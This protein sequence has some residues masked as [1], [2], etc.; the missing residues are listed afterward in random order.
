[1]HTQVSRRQ[2]LIY[3]GAATVAGSLAWA[4]PARALRPRSGADPFPRTFEHRFGSTTLDAVPSRIITVGLTDHEVLL[5][6]GVAPLAVTEWFGDQPY[7]AWPWALDALGD[8]T[9]EVLGSQETNFEAIAAHEPDLVLACYGGLEDSDY[10]RLSGIAPT[11]AQSGDYADWTTPWPI[12]TETIARAVGEDAAGA[13]LIAGIEQRFA[14]IRD[15]NPAFAGATAI[16]VDGPYDGT[17]GFFSPG[18]P[19]GRLLA[20]LGFAFPPDLEGVVP[21]DSFYGEVS[22]E[23]LPRLDSDV[24][25]WVSYGPDTQATIEADPLYPTLRAATEGRSVFLTEEETAAFGFSTVL[26]IPYLLDTFVP[27]LASAIDG[28]PET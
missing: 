8:A 19:R 15:A 27:K 3:G 12:M 25:V 7:A 28:D 24:I 10:E 16:G 26:S 4:N 1:M 2:F 20:D 14:D 13:T 22:T 17:Y 6:L 5:A 9:P 11:I 21:S 23:E 18:D